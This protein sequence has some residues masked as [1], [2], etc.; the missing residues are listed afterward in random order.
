MYSCHLLQTFLSFPFIW[1][2]GHFQQFAD[3]ILERTFAVLGGEETEKHGG[4]EWQRRNTERVKWGDQEE[5]SDR[6]HG[7]FI[8]LT[9]TS[10]A[11]WMKCFWGWFIAEPCHSVIP[12]AVSLWQ[13][14]MEEEGANITRAVKVLSSSF[15]WL[16]SI[17]CP[18]THRL[19]SSF[20]VAVLPTIGCDKKG[21]E[22][23]DWKLVFSSD[24]GPYLSK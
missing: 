3:S 6:W 24:L 13:K 17:F 2:V 9:C 1:T 11:K 12:T 5:I 22:D 20:I 18:E 23:N 7:N 16:G 21:M 19:W 4:K 8:V 15:L 10:S 14:E